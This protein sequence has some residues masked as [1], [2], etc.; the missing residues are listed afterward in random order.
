MR[1]LGYPVV[2]LDP[3]PRRF[4]S[5][6]EKHDLTVVKADAERDRYPF[7]DEHFSLLVVNLVFEHLGHDPMFALREMNRVLKMGGQ[8]LMNTP[9]LYAFD[10]VKLF[11]RGQGISTVPERHLDKPSSIGHTG[12]IRFYAAHELRRMF[13][14]TG[15]EIVKVE[16]SFLVDP[17]EPVQLALMNYRLRSFVKMLWKRVFSPRIFFPTIVPSLRPNLIV[18]ARKNHLYSEIPQAA[19]V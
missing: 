1:S 4:E 15:F 3:D 8:V 13:E 19:P 16:P 9:N 10:R 14:Y 12:P 5:F 7:D 11:L 6:T 18:V 17:W 2:G